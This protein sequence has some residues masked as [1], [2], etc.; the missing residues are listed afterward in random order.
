M[1]T[2]PA[3][4]II[5]MFFVAIV[6]LAE[7][8]HA[9]TAFV[10]SPDRIQVSG[11]NLKHSS[12]KWWDDSPFT[13][14]VCNHN[15]GSE[16]SWTG[17]WVNN[18]IRG[19]WDNGI[20]NGLTFYMTNKMGWKQKV[21]MSHTISSATGPSNR[22]VSLADFSQREVT[23]NLT[24]AILSISHQ[25]DQEY[26]ASDPINIVVVFS[27]VV[28][29][30]GN[31]RFTLIAA[32]HGQ[33]TTNTVTGSG[34]NTLVFG[35][36]PPGA[37]A[38]FRINANA[39]HLNSGTIKANVGGSQ[40]DVPIAHAAYNPPPVLLNP[41][42]FTFVNGATIQLHYD[43]G[44]DAS[45]VP[46]NADYLPIV[47]GSSLTHKITNVSVLNRLVTLTINPTLTS[48]QSLKLD[49]YPMGSPVQ[50]P[51]DNAAAIFVDDDAQTIA[52]C[53]G[54]LEQGKCLNPHSVGEN[55]GLSEQSS[56]EDTEEE[57][58]EDVVVSGVAVTSSPSVGD[59]YTCGENIRVALTFSKAVAVTGTP[60]LN[61]DMDPAN[62][63]T[64]WA[65]YTGGNGSTELT[66]AHTV[67][68]PN[69]STQGIAVLANSLQ[70]NGGSIK[71]GDRDADLSHTGLG[72]DP[73]HKVHAQ[74]PTGKALA[75]RTALLPNHPNPFNSATTIRY[76]LSQA[77][78]VKL[79]VYNVGGQPVRTLVA[80]HQGAG[81]YA[82]EWDATDDSGH[83][84]SS[85]IY[86][87]RLQA[88]GEFL[89]IKK[90]LLLK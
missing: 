30:T 14:E 47:N 88:G 79:T 12:S 34:S 69:Y 48:S 7:P 71:A 20:P 75:S 80:E 16:G 51:N 74:C 68:N 85:G 86:F 63:G 38:G 50:D 18:P 29:V 26:S 81:R 41:N 44:L 67:V 78:D 6:L 17:T 24:N 2:S 35:W 39:L 10:S 58:Q 52:N 49:Y 61:I 65:Y 13:V 15:C 56:N 8:L 60:R 28:T 64:K 5:L 45:S 87:Y 33:R 31:P 32:S 57:V 55:Q 42:D 54:N 3:K 53:T 73:T 77:M 22:R 89:E 59:T 70:L 90:M 84:L 83:S 43:E 1:S 46:D 25:D 27:R 76:D 40:V 19:A 72:H 62:W 21:R 66:F 36:T 23:N 9:Q 82:V 11:V 37:A 4:L